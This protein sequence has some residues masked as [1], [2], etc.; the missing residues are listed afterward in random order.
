MGSKF[1]VKH[2]KK[3]LEPLEDD[4]EVVAEC[5]YDDRYVLTD[6]ST[7]EDENITTPE[8]REK[9]YGQ[10]DHVRLYGADFKERLIE[11][12]FKVLSDDFIKKLGFDTIEKYALMRNES[13]FECT[14]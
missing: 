3:I 8:A 4:L 9:Y 2:L 6:I 11:S 5:R 1:T 10:E 13:I 12:G 14:K 7:Y